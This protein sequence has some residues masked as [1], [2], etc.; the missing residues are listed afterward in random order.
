MFA[1]NVHFSFTKEEK[2]TFRH[3]KRDGVGICLNED[4]KSS[5]TM[6]P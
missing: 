5:L 6:V 2:K 3:K 4:F 1:L